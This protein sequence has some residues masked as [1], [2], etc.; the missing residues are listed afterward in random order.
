M[1][2]REY[3]QSAKKEIRKI[4]QLQSVVYS[5]QNTLDVALRTTP[6]NP[7]LNE[8]QSGGGGDKY[9]NR[10]KLLKGRRKA[11]EGQVA[12]F[13]GYL[14][15][16]L[17]QLDLVNMDRADERLKNGRDTYDSCYFVLREK[18]LP[19]ESSWQTAQRFS[20]DVPQFTHVYFQDG[21]SEKHL[22]MFTQSGGSSRQL[23][24]V[25]ECDSNEVAKVFHSKFPS[26]LRL[27]GEVPHPLMMGMKEIN[28]IDR[29][30]K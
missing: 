13:G 11:L 24:I 16:A 2:Y 14:K 28:E 6:D 25:C 9:T 18:I 19:G 3:K 22:V 4:K 17:F 27:Q 10:L 8:D 30:L 20:K 21:G 12:S 15:Q 26:A 29:Q 7:W 1:D 5:L 23:L